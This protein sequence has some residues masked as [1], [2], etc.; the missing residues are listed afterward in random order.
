MF[1]QRNGKG[2]LRHY[3]GV[4]LSAIAK[5]DNQPSGLIAGFSSKDVLGW[6]HWQDYGFALGGWAT[7]GINIHAEWYAIVQYL[8]YQAT[9]T[10]ERGE[11]FEDDDRVRYLAGVANYYAIIA[12][13]NWQPKNLQKSVTT[14]VKCK[15]P[16]SLADNALTRFY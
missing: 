13:M 3:F 1:L 12:G 2:M 16:R 5:A 8:T 15:L 6:T 9:D 11:W 10:L 4:W 7:A 14:G